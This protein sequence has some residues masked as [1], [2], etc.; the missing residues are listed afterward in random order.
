[1]ARN[2]IA[3][4]LLPLTG[5]LL[6]TLTAPSLAQKRPDAAPQKTC[7]RADRRRQQ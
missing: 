3:S 2:S 1:M 4:A 6:L 7:R 5:S